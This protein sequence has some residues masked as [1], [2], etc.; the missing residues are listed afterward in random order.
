MKKSKTVKLLL[1]SAAIAAVS[2]CNEEQPQEMHVFKDVDDCVN[3]KMLTADQ[4]KAAFEQ[5]VKEN[6]NA[7]PKYNSRQLC[8]QEFGVGQCQP[9]TTQSGDVF[10]PMMAGFMA[11]RIIDSIDDNNRD[12]Y[13][14]GYGSVTPQPLYRSSSDYSSYR[15]AGNYNVGNVGSTASKTVSVKPS[16][17]TSSVKST[18]GFG[19]QAAARASWGGSSSGG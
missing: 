13:Y 5:A 11:A 14:G 7:S 17:V 12:R 6:E 18:G 1:L 4:C 16:V 8:E 9:R 15:T 19:T 10:M 2:G 3:S